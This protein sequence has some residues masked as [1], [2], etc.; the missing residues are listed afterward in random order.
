MRCG[1]ASI[2]TGCRS[3]SVR[4]CGYAAAGLRPSLHSRTSVRGRGRIR[5]SGTR[6]EDQQEG[7]ESPQ[8]TIAHPSVSFRAK[9]ERSPSLRRPDSRSSLARP[10]PGL[11]GPVGS[12]GSAPQSGGA[13]VPD[14]R[15]ASRCWRVKLCGCAESIRPGTRVESRAPPIASRSWP[16]PPPIARASTGIQSEGC[17]TVPS[18]LTLRFWTKPSSVI[19]PGSPREGEPRAIPINR[20]PRRRRATSM[21]RRPAAP[22]ARSNRRR[23][24]LHRNHHH[25]RW[26]GAFDPEE[27][28]MNYRS[29]VVFGSPREV[30][31][32]DEM[33]VAQHALAEH[34]V[35]GRGADARPPNDMEYKETA[36]SSRSRSTR[37][38]ARS[39]PARHSTP[40]MIL[41]AGRLGRR[42]LSPYRRRR[43]GT[44]SG[45]QSR[46]RP[47]V[48]RDRL[49]PAGSLT[50]SAS[51]STGACP[52]RTGRRSLRPTDPDR[53]TL[54]QNLRGL[55][56]EVWVLFIG[57][58]VN[59]RLRHVRAAVHH[60]LS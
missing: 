13:T 39:A 28:S 34:V 7:N 16:R 42:Y 46:H 23:E 20:R 33:H 12:V 41:G 49:S 19:S 35:R 43:A 5:R 57:A 29:V 60:A 50:R 32:R 59:R 25:R 15:P 2:V 17:T 4:V 40:T 1:I 22:C 51:G 11:L 24:R 14:S 55:P 6:G 3:S 37:S 30:T 9:D 54:R 56:R 27:H 45:P 47:A 36:P 53:R 10:L 31:D 44:G 38:R 48:L 8:G 58:F 21:D 26:R 52:I 18:I